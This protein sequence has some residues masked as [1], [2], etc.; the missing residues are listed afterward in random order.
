VDELAVFTGGVAIG[1]EGTAALGAL[2]I[3]RL[4]EAPR[5]RLHGIERAGPDALALWRPVP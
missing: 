2:G 5:F 1:A 4:A 3:D